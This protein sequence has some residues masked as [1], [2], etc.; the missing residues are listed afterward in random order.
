MPRKT[1]ELPL[2][3]LIYKWQ[4]NPDLLG[5]SLRFEKMLAKAETREELRAESPHTVA[6]YESM[7]DIGMLNPV[8]VFPPDSV[9]THRV[10]IGN[11]RLAAA[12]ALG[13][14]TLECVVIDGREQIPETIQHHYRLPMQWD[15]QT[16]KYIPKDDKPVEP[17][18]T[19]ELAP[20]FVLDPG[21]IRDRYYKLGYEFVNAL[22]E[23]QAEARQAGRKT[24]A[25]RIGM[26][27]ADV[28]DA[29]GQEITPVVPRETKA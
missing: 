13:W 5:R 18:I 19:V 25:K 10:I 8:L 28:M 20:E 4:N 14:S 15:D 7:R 11:Q 24:L 26:K 1:L 27:I 16:Q 12:R 23:L 3:H 6:I 22:R 21:N 29:P 17:D 9:N 2:D